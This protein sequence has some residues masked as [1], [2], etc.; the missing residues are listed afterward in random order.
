MS[1]VPRPASEDAVFKLVYASPALQC[2]EG[3]WR[4]DDDGEVDQ[5]RDGDDQI[6]ASHYNKDMKLWWEQEK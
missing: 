4:V 2:R 5:Y 6:V 3:L 1:V